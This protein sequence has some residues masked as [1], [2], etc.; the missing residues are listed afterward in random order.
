MA[1]AA[2]TG[3][4]GVRLLVRLLAVAAIALAFGVAGVGADSDLPSP[5]AITPANVTLGM[6]KGSSATIDSTLHL[7]AA[8]PK[9]DILLALDT[10]GSMGTA[11]DD[12]R[13]DANAIVG[14]IQETIPGARFAVA[15]FKDYPFF[16]FGSPG[17][18]PWRVDQNFTTNAPTSSCDDG[19]FHVSEIQCALNRLSA[20]GGF[21][22]PE[23]YNRAFY[24][25]FHDDSLSWA[26]LDAA[27]HG[28][29]RRLAPAR[30]EHEHRLPRVPEH[31]A[32]RPRPG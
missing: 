23:A 15:D 1:S 14:D 25:A 11:I 10:T 12:A 31:L 18:Y 6:G 9:A 28:R 32:D 27:L 3:S 8:P 22:D 20:G 24:E 13:N 16:P 7:N 17:D 2:P 29:A 4:R 19:E 5:D 26:P 21:D 30:R